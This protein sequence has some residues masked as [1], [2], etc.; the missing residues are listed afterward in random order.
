MR[1]FTRVR[2]PD[3]ERAFTQVC[4][5]L[6]ASVCT[7]VRACACMLVIVCVCAWR[8]CVHFRSCVCICARVPTFACKCTLFCVYLCS[9]ELVFVRLQVRVRDSCAC[10]YTFAHVW[11]RERVFVRF[12]AGA[13]IPTGMRNK[14]QLRTI[15]Q[16]S[17]HC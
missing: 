11:A 6:N 17:K 15:M 5:C 2:A 3:C 12:I 8:V 9:I 4:A 10:G 13:Q 1:T 7:W 14:A 16:K